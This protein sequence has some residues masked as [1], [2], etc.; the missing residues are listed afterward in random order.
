MLI[1]DQNDCRTLLAMK[2]FIR[3]EY[4]PAGNEGSHSTKSTK[5]VFKYFINTL[6]R[7]GKHK[8][9]MSMMDALR[10]R[11]VGGSGQEY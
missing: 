8:W 9:L 6:G 4:H 11:Q 10:L 7:G 1:T 5:G 3:M 2:G